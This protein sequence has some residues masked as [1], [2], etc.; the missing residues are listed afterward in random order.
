MGKTTI[1]PVRP[2]RREFMEERALPASVLGPVECCELARFISVL[3]AVDMGFLCYGNN[4]GGGGEVAGR[5]GKGLKKR[6]LGVGIVTLFEFEE[7]D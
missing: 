5:S 3:D 4:I 6:G 2:W 1:W 7:A